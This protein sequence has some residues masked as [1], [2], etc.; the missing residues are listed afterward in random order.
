MEDGCCKLV[1]RRTWKKMRTAGNGVL[2]C[3]RHISPPKVDDDDG[4]LPGNRLSWRQTTMSH[5]LEQ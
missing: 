5:P 3:S 1:S 4:A 2:L